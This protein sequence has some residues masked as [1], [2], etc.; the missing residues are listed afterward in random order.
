M[1]RDGDDEPDDAGDWRDEYLDEQ[2]SQRN[3]GGP[4]GPATTPLS[5]FRHGSLGVTL[6]AAMVGLGN[7]LEGRKLEQSAVVVEHDEGDTSRER[8]VLHLDPDNPADSVVL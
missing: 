4:V 8:V 3:D 2:L 5:R 1:M 6:G 7:V